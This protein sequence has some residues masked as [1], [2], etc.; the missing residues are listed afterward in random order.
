MPQINPSILQSTNKYVYSSVA[1]IILLY[2]INSI[3]SGYVY[4][5]ECL[6]ILSL[7]IKTP[8]GIIAFGLL[9]SA[10]ELFKIF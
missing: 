5:S 2:I 1:Y 3:W 7:S 8:S 6:Y 10:I 9:L 4:V